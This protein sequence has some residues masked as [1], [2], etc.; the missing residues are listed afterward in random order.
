[1]TV[2]RV[3]FGLG[4]RLKLGIA[5]FTRAQNLAGAGISRA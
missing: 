1:V 5:Q 4:D 2:P 3:Y